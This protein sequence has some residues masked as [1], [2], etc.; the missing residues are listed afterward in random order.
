[1]CNI[2]NMQ[3]EKKSPHLLTAWLMISYGVIALIYGILLIVFPFEGL[4]I[5]Y[6][7]AWAVVAVFSE[8]WTGIVLI[9][10]V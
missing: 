4:D 10:A 8:F 5:R 9:S 6:A 1:M 7:L 2:K 3:Q